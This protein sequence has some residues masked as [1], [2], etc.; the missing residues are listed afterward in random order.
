L[1]K[2]L[3]AEILYNDNYVHRCLYWYLS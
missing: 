2:L 3:F 1:V